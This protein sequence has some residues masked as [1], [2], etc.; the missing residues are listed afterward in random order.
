M[1]ST[2]HSPALQHSSCWPPCWQ[3]G[4]STGCTGTSRPS[5]TTEFRT[6]NTRIPSACL[7]YFRPDELELQSEWSKFIIETRL[8]LVIGP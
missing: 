3:V 8:L 7:A 5:P 4:V 1:P 6:S 2:N